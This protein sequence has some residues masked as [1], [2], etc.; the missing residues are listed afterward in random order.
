MER[1]MSQQPLDEGSGAGILFHES[2]V[3]LVEF[4][5]FVRL[6]GDFA[7]KLANVF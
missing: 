1:R 4:V 2:V 3:L 5:A 7:F 6:G